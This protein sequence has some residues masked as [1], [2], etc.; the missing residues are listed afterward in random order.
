M[1]RR[2]RRDSVLRDAAPGPDPV[3]NLVTL[4]A[5]AGARL[6]VSRVLDLLANRQP[7]SNPRD[8]PRATGQDLPPSGNVTVKNQSQQG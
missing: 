7:A 8:L 2:T 6:L 3:A 5:V 4:G 1:G